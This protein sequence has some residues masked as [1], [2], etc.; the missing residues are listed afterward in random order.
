MS[1]ARSVASLS[2]MPQKNRSRSLEEWIVEEQVR[3]AMRVCWADSQPK[4]LVWALIGLWAPTGMPL[5]LGGFLLGAAAG[6]AWLGG[7]GSALGVA[8]WMGI[9]RQLGIPFPVVHTHPP[10]ED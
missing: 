8:G 7:L 3:E 5:F 6:G 1:G 4:W 2:P 10:H 9:G